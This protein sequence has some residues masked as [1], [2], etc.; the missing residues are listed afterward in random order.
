MTSPDQYSANL[1]VHESVP[2]GDPV[3]SLK[4]HS[5]KKSHNAE[6]T[7]SKPPDKLSNA[8]SSST[9]RPTASPSSSRSVSPNG[10]AAYA[11]MTSNPVNTR[12]GAINAPL[13]TAQDDFVDNGRDLILRSF[14]PHVAVHAS[15]DTEDLARRK[16]VKG[17]FRELLRPFGDLVLGKVVVRDSAGASRSWDNYGVRF[18]GLRDVVE[19]PPILDQKVVEPNGAFS[20]GP[21]LVSDQL[22]TRRTRPATSGDL[23]RLEDLIEHHLYMA[24][25]R[26]YVNPTHHWRR[27]RLPRDSASTSPFYAVYLRRLLSGMRLTPYETFAH[28][29]A[30]IITISSRNPSPIE[31]LRQLYNSTSQGNGKLPSWV[32]HE[33]LRYYLLVHD[34]DRDDITKSTA[35]FDQM[36]RHFGLHCHMLRLRSSECVSTDDDSVQLPQT[37]WISATEELAQV[38]KRGQYHFQPSITFLTL[39]RWQRGYGRSW[40]M[41]V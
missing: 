37:L 16:G 29:V 34:E 6:A 19:D 27:D 39:G 8:S 33:F 24:D 17:G 18:V 13:S 21:S 7:L 20:N 2:S 11:S 30:C 9:L 14:V 15:Q 5:S 38:N 32:D 3:V 35:L 1:T 41:L 28:P 4:G 31:A 25:V 36:K 12:S 23:A 22:P 40:A 26:P 10:R